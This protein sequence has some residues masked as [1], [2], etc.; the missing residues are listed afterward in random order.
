MKEEMANG[1][2][3]DWNDSHNAS[4]YKYV[5]KD[6]M[7]VKGFSNSEMSEESTLGIHSRNKDHDILLAYY[8][9][10]LRGV[11]IVDDMRGKISPSNN[12]TIQK[13][14]VVGLTFFAGSNAPSDIDRKTLM[15]TITSMEDFDEDKAKDAVKKKFRRANMLLSP[16]SDEEKDRD[17]GISY[18]DGLNA[19]TL[20]E[21]MKV[22]SDEETDDL[23]IELTEKVSGNISGAFDIE[24][25]Q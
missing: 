7:E 3:I 12:E 23:T 6:A 15:A 24:Q 25:W 11:R 4:A 22:I 1:K 2:T 17:I 20:I 10:M 9:G 13:N 8:R 16:Y 19:D 14:Y 18:D 5:L 21:G